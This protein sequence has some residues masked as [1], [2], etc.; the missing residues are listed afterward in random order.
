MPMHY[1]ISQIGSAYSQQMSHQQPK[2]SVGATTITTQN[3]FDIKQFQQN[4]PLLKPL[5]QAK[6]N[7][8]TLPQNQQDKESKRLIQLWDQ[9][10]LKQGILYCRFPSS[11]GT[12]YCDRTVVPVALRP[13]VLQE[14]HEGTLSGYLGTEKTIGKLKERF[15]WPGHYNDLHDWCQKCAQCAAR[16]TQ[17]PKPKASLVS[18]SA[19]APLELVAMD[20]LGPLP[21]STAG[22]SYILVVGDYWGEPH[23]GR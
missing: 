19:S 10:H 18:V 5:I 14:L 11:T 7:K 12:K 16:K 22:N 8:F 17:S 2:T 21:Q 1:P 6:L 15:Y 3:P 20:I 23:T 13:V 9:L 4:D